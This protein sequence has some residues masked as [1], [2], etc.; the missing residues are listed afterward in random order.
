MK[1]CKEKAIRQ[2]TNRSRILRRYMCFAYL[3]NISPLFLG[4]HVIITYLTIKIVCTK[5]YMLHTLKIE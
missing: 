1:V 2:D 5:H 4:V 3:F